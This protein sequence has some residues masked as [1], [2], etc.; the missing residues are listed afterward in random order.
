MT[1]LLSF[2]CKEIWAGKVRKEQSQPG[3]LEGIR[4]CTKQLLR[5]AKRVWPWLD[6]FS[7]LSLRGMSEAVGLD[8]L[9]HLAFKAV[10]WIEIVFWVYKGRNYI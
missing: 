6:R 2:E 5:D 1:L 10:A 8:L 7:L 3:E 4:A 9:K